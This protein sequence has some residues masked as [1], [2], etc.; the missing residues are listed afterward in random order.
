VV[1]GSSL[2]LA[3]HLVGVFADCE[4][5]SFAVGIL[6]FRTLGAFALSKLTVRTAAA[7]RL[8]A[9]KSDPNRP[10]LPGVAVASAWECAAAVWSELSALTLLC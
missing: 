1:T 10:T 7:A 3:V 4:R 9:A 5:S 6:V 8:V 2:A